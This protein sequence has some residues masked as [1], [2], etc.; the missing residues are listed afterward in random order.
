MIYLV[1]IGYT[2]QNT[3]PR[4]DEIIRDRILFLGLAPLLSIRWWQF[5][6]A[7][8]KIGVRIGRFVV[9]PCLSLRAVGTTHSL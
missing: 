5:G 6:S 9:L 1:D 4:N 7:E 2:D 8:G 3:N